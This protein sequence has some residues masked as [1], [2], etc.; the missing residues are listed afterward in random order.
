MNRRTLMATVAAGTTGLAGCLGGDGGGGFGGDDEAE[1]ASEEDGEFSDLSATQQSF[2]GRLDEK[3]DVNAA[4]AATE[5]F[6]VDVQTTGNSDEDI[7]LAAEA[8]VN[9]VEQ[10]ALDLRVHV[11]DRGLRQATFVIETAWA[12]QFKS[13]E[14]DDSEYLARIAETRTT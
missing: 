7:R 1:T 10:L 2:V 11:E 12:E 4:R 8:Y 9:F 5:A 6:V 13:G 3:L 14:I